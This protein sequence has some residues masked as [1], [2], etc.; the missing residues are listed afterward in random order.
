MSKIAHYLQEHLVGEVTDS[1][2]VRRYFSRDASILEI[3]PAVVVY[4]ANEGDVRKTVRFSWQLAQRG[5]LLPVTARGG[6][7]DTSGAAIGSGIIM[8]FVAHMNRVLA[9][10]PKKEFVTVEPGIT[11]QS[12]QQT[13]YT[14]GLFLPPAPYN[15]GYATVGGGLANNSVGE[16]SV[17]YGDMRNHVEKLSVVL[18]NGEV[19]ETGQI[20]KRE[21]NKKL[22][23]TSFEGDIYRAVDALL[24]EN[25]PLM[26]NEKKQLRT[27][28]NRSG[29]NIFD[30]KKKGGFDLTPLFLGSQGSLGIITEATLRLAHHNPVIESG[31]ISLP[32]LASLHDLLPKIV[33]LQPSVCEMINQA[34]V[35]QIT[36]LNPNQ[37]RGVLDHPGDAV[38]LIVEFDDSKEGAQKKALK[39]LEKL[40]ERAGGHWQAAHTV[41]DRE[42]V[43][44]L[45]YSVAALLWES[46]G[47][48]QAVPV[49][50]DVSLP[51]D[52]LSDFL[53]QA[54]QA[55][56]QNDLVPAFWGHA[57]DGVVRMNPVLN[58]GQVGD[59]QKLFKVSDIIYKTAVTMG[60]SITGS[61]G[62]G[63]IRAPYMGH[64]YGPEMHQVMMRV[65]K[66]FD[67]HGI[68]NR[69]VKTASAAE[70][71]TYLRSEYS[72]SHHEHLPRG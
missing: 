43:N 26:Q 60:G 33:Q 47:G 34:A 27:R 49:A 62:D 4:P 22:G 57:G 46:R 17:K 29:Y 25:L 72:R 50:E 39:N 8:N 51:L 40:A 32:D 64:V 37:L 68:L 35:Q 30:V 9:L 67:P 23:L 6:G 66:I 52:R 54:M 24:E 45:K 63:R 10:D 38:H 36:R 13:L 12:L 31:I 16:K 7:T 18:S 61:A 21:L 58:L 53:Q 48:A 59:R 41:E 65:K 14:H 20:G 15:A 71:K 11:F 1:L 69:G 3:M 42:A 56:S 55:Y 70:V 28:H 2:E 5:K 44:K 19:I